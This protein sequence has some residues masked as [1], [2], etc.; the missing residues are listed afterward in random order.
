MRESR[1]VAKQSQ[2]LLILV[3]LLVDIST[4]I[5]KPKDY[6]ESYTTIMKPSVKLTSNSNVIY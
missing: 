1:C 2:P 5:A 4:N 3:D 6:I